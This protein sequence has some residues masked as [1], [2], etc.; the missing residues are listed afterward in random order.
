MTGFPLAQVADVLP[1]SNVPLEPFCVF[2][3]QCYYWVV[4]VNLVLPDCSDME[5]R[6][7][8]GV[9]LNADHPIGHR[10]HDQL[11]HRGT[12]YPPRSWGQPDPLCFVPPEILNVGYLSTWCCLSAPEGREDGSRKSLPVLITTTTM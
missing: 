12:A 9:P 1:S 6:W 4:S 8:W 11:A 5:R 10:T 2:P 3:K 7:W